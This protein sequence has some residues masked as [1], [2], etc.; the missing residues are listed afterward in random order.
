MRQVWAVGALTA[1][2]LLLPGCPDARE[3]RVT[4]VNNSNFNV[5]PGVRFDDSDDAAA[6]LTAE[7]LTGADL[8][9]G[10]S[11]QFTFNCEDLGLIFAND[12]EQHNLFGDSE[13]SD[14]QVLLRGEDFECGDQIRFEFN[15]DFGDFRVEVFVNGGEIR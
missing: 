5:T 11:A 13:A 1:M 10:D 8:A 4:L 7:L 3:T 12:S 2:L 15:G 9:P 6:A 14:T